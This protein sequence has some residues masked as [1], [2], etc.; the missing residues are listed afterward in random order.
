MFP[1]HVFLGGTTIFLV[2]HKNQHKGLHFRQVEI[3]N[4]QAIFYPHGM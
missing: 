2:G 3:V 1:I 4:R